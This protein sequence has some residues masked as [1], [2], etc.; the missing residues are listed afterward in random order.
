MASTT[1]LLDTSPNAF[2][3]KSNNKGTSNAEGSAFGSETGAQLGLNFQPSEYS[4]LCCRGKDSVNYSGNRRFRMVSS[5]YVEKYSQADTKAAKSAIVSDIITEI[6]QAGG[7]FCKYINGAWFEVGD[8]YAREKVSSLL[9]NLLHKQ[10]RSSNKSKTAMRR[11]RKQSKK[12]AGQKLV[13]G[14]ED[15]ED[16]STLSSSCW[17]SSI[18]CLELEHSPDY[19]FF[20]MD[21]F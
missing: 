16:D 10:Y 11:A 18:D 20:D 7:N 21:V 5:M 9:R 6:R 12:P 1:N 17:G 3:A 4:V 2:I 13:D 15:S 14:T 8:H 19:D